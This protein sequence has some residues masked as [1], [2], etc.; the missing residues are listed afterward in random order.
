MGAKGRPTKPAFRV[1]DRIGNLVVT[2]YAG[3]R[4]LYNGTR[5]TH[6]Y[7]TRCSC[8]NGREVPQFY[9]KSPRSNHSCK[10]CSKR[11]HTTAVKRSMHPEV[12]DPDTVRK[13]RIAN[14]KKQ[15]WALTMSWRA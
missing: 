11:K 8:G 12:Q 13:E 4:R 2:A 5:S 10:E 6:F 1:G 9:L 15:H 3:N 14:A 7:L